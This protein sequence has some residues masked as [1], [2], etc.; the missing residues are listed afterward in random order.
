M[1]KNC[2]W[3]QFWIVYR[4]NALNGE[5]LGHYE[6]SDKKAAETCSNF[7]SV[8]NKKII[9]YRK[10][11]IKFGNPVSAIPV[12]HEYIESPEWYE[13]AKIW[14]NKVHNLCE[15][16]S[17]ILE[18]KINAHHLTYCRLQVEHENDIIIVCDD[19][20]VYLH[21]TFDTTMYNPSWLITSIEEMLIWKKSLITHYKNYVEGK[22]IREHLKMFEL[23]KPGLESLALPE[24]EVR[25]NFQNYQRPLTFEETFCNE[26]EI[27]EQKFPSASPPLL[28]IALE[29]MQRTMQVYHYYFFKRIKIFDSAFPSQASISNSEKLDLIYYQ[30]WGEDFPA[31]MPPTPRNFLR[32]VIEIVF[33]FSPGIL[34]R[35]SV[36]DITP[37]FEIVP[38]D[39]DEVVT[40]TVS[41]NETLKLT[42][43]DF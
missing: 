18:T 40:T 6:S 34:S 28:N 12:Y 38:E 15:L 17:N 32:K 2:F 24:K 41:N 23:D 35:L 31:L 5:C 14:K 11:V 16:C 10:R 39:E 4:D 19:C 33:D 8:K 36:N 26:I 9:D 13:K 29:I 42:L 7:V 30:I 27:Y 1:K 25:K 22:K 21:D 20:H 3:C 43:A 37:V